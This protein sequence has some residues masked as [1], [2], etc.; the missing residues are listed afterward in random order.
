MAIPLGARVKDKIT[1]FQGIVVARSEYLHGCWR[2]CIQPEELQEGKIAEAH[3]FDEPQVELIQENV[4][5][6]SGKEPGGTTH[7]VA[8]SKATDS[9]KF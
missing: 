3:W 6:T 2:V 5:A 7:Y 4:V 1:G 8:P 9:R